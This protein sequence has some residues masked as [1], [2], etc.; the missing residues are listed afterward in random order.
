MKEIDPGMKNTFYEDY[1]AYK[2]TITSLQM[3]QIDLSIGIEICE[4]L[5]GNIIRDLAIL[6]EEECG[7]FL[8]YKKTLGEQNLIK[9]EERRQGME[10]PHDTLGEREQKRVLI[11]QYDIPKN[12]D[13]LGYII[14]LAYNK[15]WF[16]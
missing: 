3:E 1:Q 2:A 11:A 15:G 6:D 9:K 4:R 10:K 12:I 8:K 14:K 13:L 7:L 5:L 16:R